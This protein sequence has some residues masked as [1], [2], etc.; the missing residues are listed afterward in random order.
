MT[1]NNMEIAKEIVTRELLDFRRF[2]VDLKEIKNPFQWW[3]KHESIFPVVTFLARQILGIVSSQIE[4]EHI[5]SLAGILAN[6]KRCHL[7]SKNLDEKLIFVSQNWPNDPR[8]GCKTPFNFVEF[9]KKDKII[10]EELKEFEG[11]F[12]REAIV[13]MNSLY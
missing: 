1:N 4:I 8:L 7:Q 12:K 10:E 13:D 3:E 11:G 9:I 5:F 6:L 2:H